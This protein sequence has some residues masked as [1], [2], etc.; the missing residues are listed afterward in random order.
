[1]VALLFHIWYPPPQ[2][3]MHRRHVQSDVGLMYNCTPRAH[4]SRSAALTGFSSSADL[5]AVTFFSPF[6]P[7]ALRRSVSM[8]CEWWKLE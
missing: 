6:Q 7:I 2:R 1:M 3:S 8:G 4:S 5:S